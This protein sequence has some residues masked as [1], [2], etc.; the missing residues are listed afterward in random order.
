MNRIILDTNALSLFFGGDNQKIQKIVGEADLV[1]ISPI[2]LGEVLTGFRLGT[3]EEANRKL[4]KDFLAEDV[5]E[6]IDLSYKTAEI[7]SRVKVLLKNKGQMVP[8]NDLWIAAQ[9]IET[10]SILV[11]LD[12]HFRYIPDLPLWD[13]TKL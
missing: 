6:I 13:L 3:K 9:A 8:T 4:L 7:Y 5:T 2:V 11:S 1:I 12:D 10:K